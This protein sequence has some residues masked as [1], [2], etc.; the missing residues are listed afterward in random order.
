LDALKKERKG[1]KAKN[2]SQGGKTRERTQKEKT[3]KENRLR[4]ERISD[5]GRVPI[6]LVVCRKHERNAFL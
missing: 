4:F 2:V 1:Q 3:R 6:H 5:P